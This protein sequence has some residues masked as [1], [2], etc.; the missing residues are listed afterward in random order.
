MRPALGVGVAD[1]HLAEGEWRP[2]GMEEIEEVAG[3]HL[4]RRGEQQVGLAR[5]ERVAHGLGPRRVGRSDIIDRRQPVLVRPGDVDVGEVLP[6]VGRR[7]LDLRL[8]RARDRHQVLVDDELLEARQLRPGGRDRTALGLVS[9]HLVHALHHRHARGPPPARVLEQLQVGI[10]VGAADPL[11]LDDR[12]IDHLGVVKHLLE[13]RRPKREIRGRVR[14][15][16]FEPVSQRFHRYGSVGRRRLERLLLLRTTD[17]GECFQAIPRIIIRVA[18]ERALAI[19]DERQRQR[20][21]QIRLDLLGRERN[22]L[23]IAGISQHPH[24]GFGIGHDDV[25][26]RVEAAVVISRVLVRLVGGVDEEQRPLGLGDQIGAL[27]PLIVVEFRRIELLGR[28]NGARQPRLFIGD[29]GLGPI[30]QP[31]VI[32]MAASGRSER[33]VGAEGLLDIVGHEFRPLSRCR[34]RRRSGV[35]L[36][37][38]ARAA[39]RQRRGG[40][41]RQQQVARLHSHS[42][43]MRGYAHVAAQ[44]ARS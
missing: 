8:F 33:R 17:A 32:F 20:R 16:R 22:R 29:A 15:L 24:F 30:G 12:R 40:N 2:V 23:E 1:E 4:V 25:G 19:V 13:L 31:P 26:R 41:R 36:G 34:G 27:E 10:E 9:V 43:S 14:P 7:L 18:A 39:T 28:G 38:V 6:V 21:L 11:E 3:P 5:D 42:P 37:L 35:G 44:A